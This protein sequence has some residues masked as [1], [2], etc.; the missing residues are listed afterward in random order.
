M[1]KHVYLSRRS[2]VLANTCRKMAENTRI[3]KKK[4]QRRERDRKR[5]VDTFGMEYVRVKYPNIYDE[6]MDFYEKTRENNPDK[7][8][9]RKTQDFKRWKLNLERKEQTTCQPPIPKPPATSELTDNLELRIPLW[10]RDSLTSA[11]TLQTVADE[12]LGEGTIY[13]SLQNEI[14]NDLIEK[15]LEELREDPDLQDIFTSVE[16]EFEFEQLGAEIVINEDHGLEN[17][18]PLW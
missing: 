18:L 14:S 8:D 2:V 9:L 17:E 16:K 12:V 4:E 1:A 15:I 11:Q 13:P 5:R 7:C 3:L 6:S 10:D